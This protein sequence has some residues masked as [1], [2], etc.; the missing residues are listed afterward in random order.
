MNEMLFAELLSSVEEMDKIV[1][2]EL[3][4]G[5]VTSVAELQVRAIREKT[6]LSQS[7]FAQLIGV[8]K[9]TLENW[10]QGRR[11]PA[12]PARALLKIVSATP[13]VALKSLH[14]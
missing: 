10:E 8:S 12:G 1:R 7:R 11:R 9:R 13:E 5:R 4:P 2:G 14:G 3:E 6:G